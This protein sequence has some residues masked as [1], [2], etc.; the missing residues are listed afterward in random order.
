MIEILPESEGA[1]LVL[2]ASGSLTTED[3]EKVLI[4]RLD[5]L[6]QTHDTLSVLI[7]FADD[8]TCWASPMA[9]WDDMKIG[10]K[11]GG[12]FRRIALVGAPDWVIWG[13]K[14]YSL[15]VRGEVKAFSPEERDKA[16]AWLS[17]GDDKN[18]DQA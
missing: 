16:L 12:D 18:N 6:F 10:L 9:A 2:R 1:R 7:E 13:M 11:H 8:F 17:E 5:A 14:F 15:F 4:P 3:Y